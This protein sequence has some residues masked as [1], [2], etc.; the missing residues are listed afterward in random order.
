[1]RIDNSRR[2]ATKHRL[3]LLGESIRAVVDQQG[4]QVPLRTIREVLVA[5]KP[6]RELS[7]EYLG[8]DGWNRRFAVSDSMITDNLRVIAVHSLGA[9]VS[10]SEDDLFM[11]VLVGSES[12]VDVI[13]P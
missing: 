10:T 3:A 13:G 6:Y 2:S 9:D 8:S 4:D 11:C 7:D 1:M 12:N 5:T